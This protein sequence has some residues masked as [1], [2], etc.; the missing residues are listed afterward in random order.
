VG[1]VC[2]QCAQGRGVAPRPG[3]RTGCPQRVNPSDRELAQSWSPGGTGTFTEA[4]EQMK[5]KQSDVL[6]KA[7]DALFDLLRSVG[8]I[9][10]TFFSRLTEQAAASSLQGS[11][12]PA[13]NWSQLQALDP[14][15][16]KVGA[17]WSP[18]S[19]SVD[20]PMLTDDLQAYDLAVIRSRAHGIFGGQL[21]L[22]RYKALLSA[23]VDS[24]RSVPQLS[25]CGARGRARRLDCL[26]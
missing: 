12:C 14:D 17:T 9:Q 6:Q 1:H 4:I 21:I 8:Y 15:F 3:G 19:P 26:L 11:I 20:M 16:V 2:P 5:F 7:R 10:T 24:G 18:S 23:E 25:E 22:M 13:S